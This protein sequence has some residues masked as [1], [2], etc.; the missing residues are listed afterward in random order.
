MTVRKRNFRCSLSL[1]ADNPTMIR[2]NT[3]PDRICEAV[4]LQA[5]FGLGLMQ[6]SRVHTLLNKLDHD[7]EATQ[8]AMVEAGIA[9][10][11]ADCAVNS[12]GTCCG[13]RTGHKCSITIMLINLLLGRTLP[14]EP[15]DAEHC[16]F[17]TKSGC[18]LR[19]RHVICVNFVCQRL[20]EA[21]A[22]RQLCHVQEIAGREMDALFVLEELI[23][24][25][26]GL[27][28]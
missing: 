10:E 15:A 23:R 4:R 20:K 11:C 6:D 25:K 14:S 8:T 5:A 16:H 17:L 27:R 19:A 28:S 9:E 12:Q 13:V 1:Q 22:H 18:A 2:E 24:E 3:I 26:I 7:I 21:I